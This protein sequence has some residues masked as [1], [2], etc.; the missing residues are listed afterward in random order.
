[1]NSVRIRTL[2]KPEVKDMKQSIL[3]Y[4]MQADEILVDEIL[5]AAVSRRRQLYPDWEMLYF[6]LPKGDRPK[7]P[8]YLV[9]VLKLETK[10]V[11]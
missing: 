10:L 9:E 8:D 4:I 1:M 7:W 3:A 2:H 6:A 11:L 5:E